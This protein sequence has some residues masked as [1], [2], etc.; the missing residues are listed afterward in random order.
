MQEWL[1]A[2]SAPKAFASSLAAVTG[3]WADLGEPG[4]STWDAHIAH[5]EGSALLVLPYAGRYY[6]A[7]LVELLTPSR[8]E[9]WRVFVNA[10][11]GGANDESR[12]IGRPEPMSMHFDMRYY[13]SSRAVLDATRTAMTDAEIT[14]AD[15]GLKDLAQLKFHADADAREAAFTLQSLKNASGLALGHHQE[16]MNIAFHAHRFRRF[17]QEQCGVAPDDLLRWYTASGKQEPP[18]TIQAGQGGEA[19]TTGFVPSV[20]TLDGT[21]TFQTASDDGLTAEG[22]KVHNP[23]RD[24]ELI[25]HEIAH[26]LMWLLH[27]APFDSRLDSVPFGRALLEGY[28]NYLAR[29]LAAR[30]DPGAGQWA[31]ASYPDAIWRQR[32]SVAVP[33]VESS[34]ALPRSTIGLRLLPVP[35]YY[36]QVSTAGL[37]V[38]DVGMIWTRAL[39]DIRSYLADPAQADLDADAEARIALADRLVMHSYRCVQGWSASFE[40]AAEGLIAAAGIA[41]NQLAA[42]SPARRKEIVKGIQDRFVG[43]GILAER[44]IQAIGQVTAGG[45]TRWL[46]GADSGLRASADPKL[47][48]NQ[49]QP[50]TAAGNALSGV[51]DLFVDGALVYIATEQG[52]FRWD[53]AAGGQAVP[54]GNAIAAQTPRCVAVVAGQ[55][56]AGTNY[57]LWRFDGNQ[58]A[59]GQ[60]KPPGGIELKLAAS[61]IMTATVGGQDF[62]LVAALDHLRCAKLGG[63]GAAAPDWKSP[64]LRNAAG[65]EIKPGW[66]TSICLVGTMLY[67]ATAYQGVWPVQL[68]IANGELQ[69]TT[70]G[71]ALPVS[72]PPPP[73]PPPPPKDPGMGKVLRLINDGNQKLYA[74]TTTGLFE[75][76]LPAGAWTRV[77]GSATSPVTV[78]Q[79]SGGAVAAGTAAGGLW[80]RQP[81]ASGGTEVATVETDIA[82]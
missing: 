49:W 47:L 60:W 55:L 76:N 46:A 70:A 15:A 58:Q 61:Q 72:P 39:W 77:A 64:T 62:C 33:A 7:Y 19:L 78:V 48:W 74:G 11:N 37:A 21:V 29:S 18:L 40:T 17:F 10:E 9:G 24:P 31:R 27:R 4:S 65:D 12:I 2:N 80:V 59:W 43:R 13:A 52:I 56:V 44:G 16:G 26:A 1:A 42:L 50:I 25:Y 81:T 8:D 35:N 67:V 54:V 53:A 22:G 79:S 82:V 23:S 57:T 71:V 41:L 14:A 68:S 32:W 69:A 34:P 66:I 5:Y 73:P 51:T 30:S 75:I 38:Y 28:A 45:S 20:A 63:G 3:A 36:P 6:L